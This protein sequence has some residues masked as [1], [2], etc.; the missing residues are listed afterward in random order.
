[1]IDRANDVYVSGFDASKTAGIDVYR[2]C[3]L[4]FMRKYPFYA[5]A[6]TLVPAI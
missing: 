1:L 6:M 5:A 2:G 4:Q 3:G